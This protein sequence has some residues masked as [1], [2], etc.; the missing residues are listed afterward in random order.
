ML[1]G[2]RAPD[3]ASRGRAATGLFRLFALAS[4]LFLI[5]SVGAPTQALA[6]DPGHN[7][8][9][10]A[11]KSAD[12]GGVL[13][14]KII[15]DTSHMVGNESRYL[16]ANW[17]ITH[18]TTDSS[19]F[20][21]GQAMSGHVVD[22]DVRNSD[23][24]DLPLNVRIRTNDD[25]D[26]E[27]DETFT[28]T[29]TGAGGATSSTAG[30]C[31]TDANHFTITTA[32]RTG[33]IRNNDG[34]GDLTPS[35]S[36]TS[37]DYT[38]TVG[39]DIGSVVLPAAT[40][41]DGT[42]SYTLTPGA[43]I[44]AEV[45]FDA[46]TRTLSGTPTT[47]GIPGALTLTA[48]DSDASD[49]DSATLA[50]NIG[51]EPAKP[52]GFTAAAGDAQVTLTWDNPG[53]TGI[54]GYQV[55]GWTGTEPD[56]LTWAGI[57][58]SGATTVSY[59]AIQLTNDAA[60]GYRIRAMAGSAFVV[61]EA[62]DAATATPTAATRPSIPTIDS[63]VAGDGQLTVTW[64]PPDSDG[65]A[66]ITSYTVV[67]DPG[68]PADP[69][70]D[71]AC[72]DTLDGASRSCT[73]TGLTNGTTYTVGVRAMNSAGIGQT[74]TMTAT[75]TAA[76]ANNAPTITSAAAID[77]AE[78]ATAVVTVTATDPDSGDTVTFAKNGGADASAFSLTS[79]GVLTFTTAPDYENPTDSD[80]NN[81]Y[82]VVVR[83]TDSGSPALTA[84]QTITVTVTDVNEQA[85]GTAPDFGSEDVDDQTWRV[86][87]AITAVTLPTATG[88]EGTLSYTL[89]PDITAYGLTL[90]N[91]ALTREISGTPTKVLTTATAFTWTATDDDSDTDT[92]TFDV[93]IG[94]G[95]QTLIGFAYS[96]DAIVFND[97]P[98]AVTAPTGNQGALSYASRTATVCTV[99]SA[100]GALTI[101]SSG[102]CTVRATAAA[103]DDYDEATVD[104][105]VDITPAVPVIG[106]TAGD[107][108]ITLTWSDPGDTGIDAW[109][110]RRC[111][112]GGVSC[113]SWTAATAGEIGARTIVIDGTNG[114][115]YTAKLRAKA[116]GFTSA[117]ATSDSITPTAGANN[118]PTAVGTISDMTLTVGG[119][120]SDVDVAANFSDADNDTLTYTAESGDPSVAAVTVSGSIVTVTPVA[121]GNAR[122][123]VTATDPGG[124]TATQMFTAAVNQP[125]DDLIP[126]FS[127]ASVAYGWTV[128]ADIGRAQLPAAAGGDGALT[129]ELTD[130]ADI[131]A[132]VSYDDAMRTFTGT[133]TAAGTAALT[134]TAT[135][136]DASDPDSAELTVAITVARGMQDLSGFAYSPARVAVD[137]EAPAL[138]Y[139]STTPGVCTVEADTGALTLLAAGACTVE[140][141]AAATD[142][143][144]AA[145]AR[146]TVEVTA[147]GAETRERLAA[148]NESVLPELGRALA[149]G[150]AEAVTGRLDA[151]LSGGALPA[152]TGFADA[153]ASV[154]G[155]L[156][157]NERALDEGA[158]SWR[159][160]LSGKSFALGL[161]GSGPGVG[162]VAFWGSGDWRSLS[163]DDDAAIE[164]EGEAF[165]AA[166]GVDADLGSDVRAGAAL[167]RSE[168]WIDYT[169]GS[170]AAA[171]EGTLESRMTSVHPYAG[172]S[173]ADGGRLWATAGW[174]QGEIEIDDE[175]A[176]RGQSSDTALLTAAVGGVARLSSTDATAF[177]LKGEAQTARLEI[178]DN[179]DLIDGLTVNTR[180]LRLALE[181]SRAF[182]LS[183]GA[184]LTPSLEAG[185]RWDGGD[186]AT[187]TGV[188]LGAGVGWANRASGL[189]AAVSGRALA[190]HSGGLREW[191][192]SG[193]LRLAPDVDGRGLS[194][195]VSPSWG[196][197]GSRLSQLWDDGMTARTADGTAPVGRIEAELGYGLA[198]L[199]GVGVVTPYSGAALADDGVR[200]YRLG[201]RF[202]LGAGLALSLE[203]S[204]RES[205]SDMA[206]HGIGLRGALRW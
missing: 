180:R 183:S 169:D 47:S 133:P 113:T 195:S 81:T 109:D 35:F 111:E 46:A 112:P 68:T 176:A 76:V 42:L 153:L 137:D 173:L 151:A 103:T 200:R 75:P 194:L 188:E 147:A 165:T 80:T 203:A 146:F 171:V 110:W 177:D 55:A 190:G 95:E 108:S 44:P 138:T 33:T 16:C 104:A 148:V 192:A 92:V 13:I 97:N 202:G 134:L 83:A 5:G 52:T 155:V 23:A 201:G 179:G 99:D 70:D 157:A 20:A 163:L 123:T 36:D 1:S 43:N 69:S 51:I 58:G 175:G 145:T 12:E 50:V 4:L 30:S 116:G 85:T 170:G 198:A 37:V 105:G 8:S 143:Y 93:T 94:K 142:G 102:V 193:F 181:G 178:D 129:Y 40:G 78:N 63:I 186:G 125:V 184:T 141:T 158:F 88:G 38:W 206:D 90:T 18:G 124:L 31:P 34:Q 28:F 24:T 56:T 59:T 49:P 107:G 98:P 61:S 14:F 162:D 74:A 100:S 150:A 168:G 132:G 159:Q 96:P 156:K 72:P 130:K 77:V 182:A 64:S 48:T 154:A 127:P 118:A 139:A 120:A 140:A 144:A 9:V 84:D 67:A 122:I 205:G 25:S 126:S 114:T 187:G 119:S 7:V 57:P 166:L 79:A 10:E 131:P 45:S 54:T 191:G 17:E 39:T 19:D 62:S 86:G 21:Q 174:G 204:R 2:G 199:D 22:N 152:A 106:V 161:S 172:L 196:E 3:S 82:I 41:G 89:E 128:G 135:D 65:G 27:P 121:A 115:A 101:L 15:F 117:V 136:S 6:N 149:A 66:D 91:T 87:E 189:T 26:F 32:S 185:L 29:V 197:T 53:D 60:Y 11:D 167:S 73:I 160:A 164:W 71:I